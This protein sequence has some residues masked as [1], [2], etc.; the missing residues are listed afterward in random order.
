MLATAD[1]AMLR[2]E[3]SIEI[4]TDAR[5]ASEAFWKAWLW[6]SRETDGRPS[7]EFCSILAQRFRISNGEVCREWL[8]WYGLL[9]SWELAAALVGRDVRSVPAVYGTSHRRA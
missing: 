6:Q 7:T 8:E 5:R 9:T 3:L 2:L 1:E 4:A